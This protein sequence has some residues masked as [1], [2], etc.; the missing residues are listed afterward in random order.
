MKLVLS[1]NKTQIDF[2]G[3]TAKYRGFFGGIGSGK[4][5]AGALEILRQPANTIGMVVAP[6]YPMLRDSTQRLFFDV[7]CPK[8]YILSHNKSQNETK[9]KNGST[10][11]WRSADNPDRLR[12]PTLS[13]VYVDEA[14]Y[15]EDGL[16]DVLIG[17]LRATPPPGCSPERVNRAWITTTPKGMSHWTYRVF[18]EATDSNYKIFQSKTSNNKYIPDDFY[19]NLQKSYGGKFALQELDGLFIDLGS[20]FIKKN[21]IQYIHPSEV[22]PNLKWVRAWDLAASDSTKADSTASIQGALDAKTNILYLRNPIKYQLLW[23]QSKQKII[24]ITSRERIPVGVE[25]LLSWK[26]ATDDLK[27]HNEMNKYGFQEL[28]PKGDKLSKASPWA[29]LLA[30]GNIRLIDDSDVGWDDFIKEWCG[31][32]NLK[33]D[34]CVDAVSLVYFMLKNQVN[35]SSVGLATPISKPNNKYVF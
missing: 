7:I 16:W 32:P 2:W 11:L 6:T 19:A 20:D 3:S 9:L 12:G 29:A 13:W 28:R 25:S 4:S 1:G 5:Y 22:P 34:D 15:T 30:A 35:K 21:D 27:N 33:H 17:R 23:P 8:E 24:D 18:G 26:V 31:F 10:I 14:A